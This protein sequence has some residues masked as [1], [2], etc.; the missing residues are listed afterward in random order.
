MSGL[1]CVT[2]RGVAVR[3]RR[4]GRSWHGSRI[5]SAIPGCR[6]CL[7]S[8]QALRKRDPCTC[9]AGGDLT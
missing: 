8:Y 6:R 1:A 2:G 5:S 7:L 3:V 4:C 9:V